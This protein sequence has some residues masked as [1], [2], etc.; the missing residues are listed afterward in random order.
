MIAGIDPGLGGAVAF[1][2]VGCEIHDI[3]TFE[4]KRGKGKRRDLDGY[5]LMV[6]IE[7]HRPGLDHVFV[8]QAQAMPGQAAYA[9]GI[10]FQ[11]YGEIRGILVGLRVPFTI[12][13]PQTWKRALVV[14][15][16]KDGAR[17]RASQLLPNA[18][19]QWP[20]K[21]HDG[22]AE[23]ALIALY[24]LRSIVANGSA[25]RPASDLLAGVP[26]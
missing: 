12:V 14:P 8:E 3:P 24:G 17:A 5:S 10:F 7:R 2:G 13:H 26:P 22:R 20:L 23:A 1:L 18:A 15:K 4:I 11:V 21:K 19:G 6:L 16:E 25:A 9:T